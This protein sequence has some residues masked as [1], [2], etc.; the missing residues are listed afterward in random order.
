VDRGKYAAAKGD[1]IRLC[2]F[3]AMAKAGRPGAETLVDLSRRSAEGTL[4][5]PDW[6]SEDTVLSRAF[7]LIRDAECLDILRA[8]AADEQMPTWSRE[9]ALRALAD[10]WPDK[11]VP[12]ILRVAREATD[13]S[14]KQCAYCLAVKLRP[15]AARNELLPLLKHHN[16][17]LRACGAYLL[18][19]LRDAKSKPDLIKLLDDEDDHVRLAALQA[20]WLMECVRRKVRW[21]NPRFQTDYEEFLRSHAEPKSEHNK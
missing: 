16:P 8:T 20:L 3:D 13:P 17:A 5:F 7:S 10:G 21:A 19:S 12:T 4:N 15:A 1:L 18:G 2:L 14:V 11:E 9:G 6:V